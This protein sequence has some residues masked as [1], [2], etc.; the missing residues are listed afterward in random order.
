VFRAYHGPTTNAYAAAEA[1]G[2]TEDLQKE[3]ADLFTIRNSSPTANT[4]HPGYLA[5]GQR[6]RL[7]SRRWLRQVS[8]FGLLA[9]MKRATDRQAD[10][11][12]GLLVLAEDGAGLT[13]D[14]EVGRFVDPC[15]A[16][17]PTPTSAS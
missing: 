15:R 1:N 12:V 6:A 2:R 13:G 7:T 10:A 14:G 11:G 16:G 9:A 3:Q 8:S 4:T 17:S 5:P